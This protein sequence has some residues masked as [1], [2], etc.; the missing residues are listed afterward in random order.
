MNGLHKANRTVGMRVCVCVCACMCMR[1]YVHAPTSP[2]I[3]P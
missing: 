3:F 1:V 2:S